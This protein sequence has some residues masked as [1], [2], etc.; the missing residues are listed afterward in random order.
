MPASAR[1][2]ACAREELSRLEQDSLADAAAPEA[3][4]HNLASRATME[5]ALSEWWRDDPGHTRPLTLGMIEIDQLSQIQEKCGG[6]TSN[7]LLLALA[8]LLTGVTR[9][10]DFAARCSGQRLLIMF[11]DTAARSATS[12]VERVRQTVEATQF[13]KGPDAVPV[14]LTC[15]VAEATETDTT[16]SLLGRL[17]A[18]LA[19]ARGYGGNRTFLHEGRFPA[20]VVPP[21]F[22][23]E[24]RTVPI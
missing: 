8:T 6:Q 9:G 22:S 4:L 10:D 14:S 2:S 19:E 13:F 7:N 1:C 17:E 12:A 20:P 11:P 21:R 18:T 24:T 15:A 3:A 23:L 5:R 16:E